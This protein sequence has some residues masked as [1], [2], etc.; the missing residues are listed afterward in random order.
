MNPRNIP[1]TE[2]AFRALKIDKAW[3][4]GYTEEQLNVEIPQFIDE[5]DYTHYIMSSDD[6]VP[7]QTALDNVLIGMQKYNVFTGWCNIT[8]TIKLANVRLRKPPGQ[9]SFFS[10]THRVPILSNITA[11]LKLRTFPDPKHL[12]DGFFRVYFAGFSFTS[13]TRELWKRFPFRALKTG[14]SDFLLCERLNDNNIPIYCHKNTYCYHLHWKKDFIIGK[15]KPSV[16][17]EKHEKNT[18]GFIT[19]IIKQ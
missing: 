6:L 17:L 8:P 3:F 11:P 4:R 2:T 14:G 10:L 15:V 16:V 18:P 13:L 19:T 5:T 9:G 1:Q 7:T 12:P